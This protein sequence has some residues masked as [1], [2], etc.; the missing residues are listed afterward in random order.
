MTSEPGRRRRRGTPI[1]DGLAEDLQSLGHALADHTRGLDQFLQQ[2]AG[3]LEARQVRLMAEAASVLESSLETSTQAL[4]VGDDYEALSKEELRSI[5]RQHKLRRWSHFNRSQLIAFL[6][7][8]L[9]ATA[10]DNDSLGAENDASQ[11]RQGSPRSFTNA[12]ANSYPTDATRAERLLL[13][14]LKHMGVAPAEIEA[15]W[16]AATPDSA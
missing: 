5:C 12:R 14:L 10:N 4:P 3:H 16:G 9:K 15:A 6:R 2:Q 11:S 1:S 8:N 7:E 13:L